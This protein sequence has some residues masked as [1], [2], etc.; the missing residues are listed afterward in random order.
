MARQPGSPVILDRGEDMLVVPDPDPVTRGR[1][2]ALARD[3]G[4]TVAEFNR[5]VRGR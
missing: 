1:A 4:I 5:I 2:R 3:A